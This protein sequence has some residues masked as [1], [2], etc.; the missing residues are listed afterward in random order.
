[1]ADEDPKSHPP[2]YAEK[3]PDTWVSG[4]DSMTGAQASYLKTLSEQ[5]DDADAYDDTTSKAEASK[6]I[7]ALKSKLVKEAELYA[8]R[9]DT[10]AG[11]SSINLIIKPGGYLRGM[12]RAF[13][14][15]QLNLMGSLIGLSERRRTEQAP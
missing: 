1:M 15:S 13:Q 6:R 10:Y 2:D 8:E 14:Q 4:E 5:A 9:L 12:T 3:D 11:S 7:D